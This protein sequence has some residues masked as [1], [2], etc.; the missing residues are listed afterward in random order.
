M[1][2]VIPGQAS[3]ATSAFTRVHSPSKT[4]VKTPLWTRYGRL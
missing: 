3:P 4:G 2:C 1:G